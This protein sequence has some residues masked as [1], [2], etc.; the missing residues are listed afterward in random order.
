MF[1]DEHNQLL[2]KNLMWRQASVTNDR[3]ENQNKKSNS[4]FEKTDDVGKR[5]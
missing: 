4:E 5:T 3:W 2:Q 1:F